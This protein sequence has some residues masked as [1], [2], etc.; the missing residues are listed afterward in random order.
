MKKKVSLITGIMITHRPRDEIKYNQILEVK[1]NK[2]KSKFI[3]S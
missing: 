2:I 3:D 1:D